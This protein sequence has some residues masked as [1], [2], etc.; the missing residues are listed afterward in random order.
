MSM[1]NETSARFNL[2]AGQTETV[3]VFRLGGFS[4][5]MIRAE[6]GDFEVMPLGSSRGFSLLSGES[7]VRNREDY[8]GISVD[9][10]LEYRVRNTGDSPGQ[11]SVWYTGVM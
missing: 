10:V 11:V 2:N 7:F 5:F 9:T 1:I 8:V 6:V 3:L 4:S